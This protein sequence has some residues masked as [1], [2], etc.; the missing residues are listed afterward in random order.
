ML[1]QS[2]YARIELG[3]AFFEVLR[4]RL[5]EEDILRIR[6]EYNIHAGYDIR[7]ST[8]KKKPHVPPERYLRF[9]EAQLEVGLCFP[10]PAFYRD[11]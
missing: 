9:Y 10:L 6:D 5:R 3:T 11:S 8:S 4:S 7:V 1:I 2:E